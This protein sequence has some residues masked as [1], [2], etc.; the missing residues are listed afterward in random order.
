MV[1]GKQSP[2][3][4]P[5]TKMK[6]KV[7]LLTT[8]VLASHLMSANAATLAYVGWQANVEAKQDADPS[9]TTSSS[10]WR[11]SST[12]KTYDIDGDN[13]LGTDGWYGRGDASIGG[14]VGDY[15]P[16][17]VT[18]TYNVGS[19]NV[20]GFM[21][22]PLDPA[23]V[24]TYRT[25]LWGTASAGIYNGTGLDLFGFSVNGT[26]LESVP[27]RIGIQFDSWRQA[28]TMEYHLRQ[29]AGTGSMT[30]SSGSSER[31][32]GSRRTISTASRSE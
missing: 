19:G 10:G 18:P 5:I 31:R 6:A 2:H 24:D 9:P 4:T 17:Y 13:I 14:A 32:C 29:T 15:L 23:G 11:N 8:L 22:N 26:S 27:L 7:T 28:G 16:S 30:V 25:G 3:Q 21:D 12:T 1:G 20:F